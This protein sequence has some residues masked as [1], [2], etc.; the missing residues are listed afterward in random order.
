MDEQ[1]PVNHSVCK[2]GWGFGEPDLVEYILA[3]GKGIETRWS[4]RF[5]P[6]QTI[7]WLYI[8]MILWNQC[9]DDL[10]AVQ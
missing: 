6:I 9:R 4:L 1:T 8:S 2:V 3:G 7:L 10:I 5:L